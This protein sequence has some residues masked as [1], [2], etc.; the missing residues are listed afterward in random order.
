[1]DQ[2]SVHMVAA[3]KV[4][5]LKPGEYELWRM[6]MEQYIQMIDYSLWEVIENGN[7]PP[8]TKV[9]KS[10]ETTIA[11]TTAEEK[12]QRRLELKARSTLLMGIPNEHQLKFNSI[13]DAKSLLQAVEKRFGGNAATKKTQRNLLNQLEIHGE[14]ISKEDVNQKFLRSLSPEWNTHTIVW[15]NKPEIDT[16]SLDDLYNNLK[17]YEPEVKGTSSSSTNIQNVAFVSSNSTSSTNGAV[18]TAHDATTA[19][20]Q[21]TTDLQK[22]HP[23]DLEEIDLRWQ[24]A[25]LTMR[26]RRFLKNTGRKFSVN[27]P[28]E[29]TTSN[30]LVSCDGSGYDW[31]D[32][33]EDGPTNFALMAYSSTSSNTEVSTDSNC[34]SSCLENVKILKEQN[35]QLLKDLKTSKLNAIAYKTGLEPVDARLLV[36]KK[37]ESVYEEDSKIVDK[38]KTGLGYNVVPPPYIGNFMPP[39]FD[40]TFSGLEEFTSEPIIIKPIVEKSKAKTSEAKPEAV[41]KNNGA[42]I[43]EDWVS[44]SEEE[45][46]S[47]TKIEK[48]I[49]NPSFVKIDFIKAKQTKLIG[50][51]LNKLST[52]GKTLIFLEITKETRII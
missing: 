1:M 35:E 16:L 38:C 12:A 51:L 4:P 26:A 6:R 3:S 47:Q 25:M 52:I 33:A 7:A 28:V 18:N 20:T 39:K 45:N 42:L 46:V 44:D 27:V 23:D 31:S 14:S 5:M 36:Y 37:N 49:A 24:M 40:L 10:V 17:I 43:I 2:D 32:Q 41:R 11:P 15:R 50:K 13:K 29:T 19:S 34:S 30:A 22:I 8:I 48:K 21:A 9:V